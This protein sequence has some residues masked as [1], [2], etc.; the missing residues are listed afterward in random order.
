M[1]RTALKA[2]ARESLRAAEESPK[3]LTLYY[4]LCINVPMLLYNLLDLYVLQAGGGGLSGLSTRNLYSSISS[5]LLLLLTVASSIWTYHYYY[6]CLRLS[7]KQSASFHT[8]LE[9]FSMAGR[10]LLTI[11]LTYFRILL[12]VFIPCLIV[13]SFIFFVENLNLLILALFIT[14]I[15]P[16]FVMFYRCRLAPY[17]LFDQNCSA[18]E[19]IRASIRLTYGHKGQLFLLDLSFFWYFLL[20]ALPSIPGMLAIYGI[21]LIP[22]QWALAFD[23]VALLIQLVLQ[24]LLMPYVETTRAHAYNWILERNRPSGAS[25]QQPPPVYL[26]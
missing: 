10:V 25:D 22:Q 26:P 18:S 21:T 6:Y 16:F 23:L 9:P 2:A 24:A 3:K 5:L 7:R 17:I 11:V 13:S 12:A 8:F 14:A 20:L 4:L 1:N 15:I 19:A